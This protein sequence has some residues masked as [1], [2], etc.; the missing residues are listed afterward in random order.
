[1]DKVSEHAGTDPFHSSAAMHTRQSAETD[2]NLTRYQ[3]ASEFVRPR[4][5]VVDVGCPAEAGLHYLREHSAGLSFAGFDSD[6]ALVTTED[7]SVDLVLAFEAF[8]KTSDRRALLQQIRRILIPGGRL[9][10]AV[11]GPMS[12]DDLAL[13]LGGQFLPE[14]LYQENP[15]TS[16]TDATSGI[17]RLQQISWETPSAD[18]GRSWIVTAIRDPLD[19]GKAVPYRETVFANLDSALHLSTQYARWYLN[20]WIVHCMVHVGYRVKSPAL[21]S[22]LATR[23]LEMSPPDSADYGAAL[24]I[25]AYRELESASGSHALDLFARKINAYIT[26]ESGNPHVLRW[27]IS[28]TFVLAQLQMKAG[29]IDAARQ[30]FQACSGMDPFAFSVHLATKTAD[31]FFWWGWLAMS[32]NDSDGARHAWAQGVAFGDTLLNRPMCEIL[33]NPTYPNIF[34]HG[35]GMREFVLAMESVTKCANGLH[36]LGRLR[37][38]IAIDWRNVH[39][40]FRERGDRL[41]QDL[42]HARLAMDVVTADLSK[43]RLDLIGRTR[44]LDDSRSDLIVR[45]AE[46]DTARD[47]LMRRTGELDESRRDLIERTR[48]LETNNQELIGRTA[49][50]DQARSEL[51]SRTAELDV[52]RAELIQR[53]ADL[54]KTCQDL[55]VRTA[56]LD[57]VRKEL[58]ERTTDLDEARRELIGRT[59]ELDAA[60][61]ELAAALKR[62]RFWRFRLVD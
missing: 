48:Q 28:L 40:T 54:D 20:P 57:L 25:L 26:L 58:I 18:A 7:H 13:L 46:L 23:L 2:S 38:G 9:I 62:G 55:I 1:M 11:P 10:L 41:D 30:L 6:A 36:L 8:G 44:E 37:E 32:Q 47:D 21:L 50:L 4:D 34:D 33:I 27:R 15:G 31:A 56:D 51:V 60:R 16:H 35:D 59:Q 19:D 39:M 42:E 3:L 22:K 53:T 24:C 5:R 61:R 45:T 52:A 17:S 29:S 12:P 43:V 49:E 14:N